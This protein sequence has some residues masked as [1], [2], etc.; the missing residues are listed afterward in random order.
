[1]LLLLL[2]Q[3]LLVLHLLLLLLLLLLQEQLLLLLLFRLA[4]ETPC[5]RVVLPGLPLVRALL[6]DALPVRVARIWVTHRATLK[7]GDFSPINIYLVRCH[8]RYHPERM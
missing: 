5:P 1:M 3:H 6:R 8:D 2:K 7:S 4:N